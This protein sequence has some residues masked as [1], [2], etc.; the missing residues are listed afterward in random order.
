MKNY[1][2]TNAQFLAQ[3]GFVKAYTRDAATNTPIMQLKTLDQ[4]EKMRAK[5]RNVFV[6]NQ[7]K[8]Q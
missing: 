3:N 5:G 2:K 4:V 6:P 1:D 8:E 7:H